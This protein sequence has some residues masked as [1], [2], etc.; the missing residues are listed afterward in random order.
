[1]IAA[2][3]VAVVPTVAIAVAKRVWPAGALERKAV[4]DSQRVAKVDVDPNREA[5][6]R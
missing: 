6:E 5:L 4:D 2:A 3:S 1:M